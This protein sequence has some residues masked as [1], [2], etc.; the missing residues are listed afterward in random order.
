[1]LIDG[2]R[3][4]FQ[5]YSEGNNRLEYTNSCTR[6][7]F[8]KQDTEILTSAKTNIGQDIT[9]SDENDCDFTFLKAV[10]YDV[11]PP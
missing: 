6:V 11:P 9:F 10:S 7:T 2:S 3:H 1:M 8:E 5:W 4:E